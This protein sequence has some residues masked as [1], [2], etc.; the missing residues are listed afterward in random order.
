MKNA[1]SLTIGAV[2]PMNGAAGP[3]PGGEAPKGAKDGPKNRQ[4]FWMQPMNQRHTI[5]KDL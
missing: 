2:S 3:A 5:F 4:M 1:M